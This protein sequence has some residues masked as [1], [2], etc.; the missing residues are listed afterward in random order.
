MSGGADAHAVFVPDGDLLVP[1]V[2]A[3]GPWDAASMHGGGPTALLA[4]AIEALDTPA[5]MRIVRLAVEFPRAVPMEPV[6]ASA[7]ITRPGKRLAL[8]EASLATADGMPVLRAN[9][10]LLRRAPV[11][12][13]DSARIDDPPVPGPQGAEP[14]TWSGAGEDHGF[15][16][17][18]AEIVVA[19]TNGTA[20]LGWFRFRM[21]LV[22]GEDPTPL[23]RAVA[24][25]DF[26]NGISRALSF[27]THLFVNTDLTV[28]LHREPT[29]EWI[30][31]DAR[32]DFGA[33]GSG[34]ATTVLLDERGRI[35]TGA[36]SLYVDER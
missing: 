3:R 20:R 26:G 8:A 25:A 1:T 11:A 17:S 10:T 33:E 34:Q 16:L 35:G 7:A 12:I 31:L 9:A 6:K 32:T 13:P 14:V 23:Q 30:G 19:R 15:H 29:G 28:H 18:A 24:F 22:A 36:Q 27:E 4:R 5:P 21:P 2:H